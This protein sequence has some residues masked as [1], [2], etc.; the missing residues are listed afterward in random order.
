MTISFKDRWHYLAA[1]CGNT[2]AGRKDPLETLSAKSCDWVI[3][4]LT[5]LRGRLALDSNHRDVTWRKCAAAV[6]G[7]AAR[8]RPRGMTTADRWQSEAR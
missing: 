2:N 4:E 5:V 8:L 7:A 3:R 6:E 1:T